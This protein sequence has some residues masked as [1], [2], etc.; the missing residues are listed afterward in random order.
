[1]VD[2]VKHLE[3]KPLWNKQVEGTNFL[4][5]MLPLS[6]T[7]FFVTFWF[8]SYL[9]IGQVSKFI[10]AS[11]LSDAPYLLEF[12]SSLGG[13]I[14]TSLLITTLTITGTIFLHPVFRQINLKIEYLELKDQISNTILNELDDDLAMD[15]IDQRAKLEILKEFTIVF[16]L[17]LVAGIYLFPMYFVIFA[18]ATIFI[19]LVLF[20]LGIPI[21]FGFYLTGTLSTFLFTTWV[22]NRKTTVE[23]KEKKKTVRDQFRISERAAQ[24]I[25]SNEAPIIC[26]GCR[27]YIVATSTICKICGES[28]DV[29]DREDR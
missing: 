13:S 23:D 14:V 17:G 3:F 28:I 8:M 1:M 9:L 11:R 22:I 29:I 7:G 16:F 26:P 19:F 4:S 25:I 5:I 24:I 6:F 2:F 18:T 27:S 20:S 12:L 15:Q 21:T 10:L